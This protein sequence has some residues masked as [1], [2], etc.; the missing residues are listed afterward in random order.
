M[1]ELDKKIK[2]IWRKSKKQVQ[3][4]KGKKCPDHNLLVSYIDGVLRDADKNKVERHLL[5]C[6]HCV[7]LVVIHHKIKEAETHEAVADVPPF[8]VNRARGLVPEKETTEGFFDI[9]L[10]FARE[11]IEIITNPG[12]LGI[13]YAAAPVPV[14]GEKKKLTSNHISLHKTFP[15]MESDVEIAK[16]RDGLVNIRILNRDIRSGRPV[17]GA[18]ISL[19]NPEREVAS[20]IAKKGEVLFEGLG[21]GI[22][23]FKI[24]RKGSEIGH[25]SFIIKE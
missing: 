2:H 10:K 11:T 8:L 21:F 22:Y 16:T 25:I 5:E 4:M 3:G 20:H 23:V 14:R 12:N 1:D 24:S 15:D 19:F 17:E 7:D 13:S 18:R 9:V 6:S